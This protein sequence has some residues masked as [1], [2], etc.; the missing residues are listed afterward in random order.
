[1]AA[2]WPQGEE[3]EAQVPGEEV[4]DGLQE[5]WVHISLRSAW[6]QTVSNRLQDPQA[7]TCGAWR[8][9]GKRL[10]S[11]WRE[12]DVEEATSRLRG[13]EGLAGP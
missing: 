10:H 1:M 6:S 8:T 4:T 13:K 7:H 2:G 12:E 5:W 3:A 9:R 11:F